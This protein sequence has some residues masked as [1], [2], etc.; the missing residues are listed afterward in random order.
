V[1]VD[2]HTPPPLRIVYFGTPAFAVPTLMAL[3][4]SRHK[5]VA[6]VSQ[7]DRPK[8]RGHRLAATPTKELAALCGVP[9][10]Q[11]T[12][13]REDT[14]L[15]TVAE[16][17]ADLGV[18]AAYGRILPDALLAIPRL[19]MINVHASLLPAWRGAAPV[20]RAVIA[21]DSVTGVT[22]MRVVQELDAG[23]MLARVTVPIGPDATSPEIETIL[24][25][26]G[27]AL[28]LDVVE[29]FAAGAVVETPQDHAQATFAPKILKTEGP[30]DWSLPAVRIH[31]L[32]RGLQPW[33]LASTTVD[34]ARFLIHRTAVATQANEAAPGTVVR[35]D[36][37]TLAVA[38]GAGVLEILQIQPEGRRPMTV[39]EFLSGHRVALNTRLPS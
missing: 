21:G 4:K 30:I 13:L 26:R 37:D 6:V 22:I 3:L 14:F 28:L 20:H 38:T 1:V 16:L 7:P 35:A 18:V 5:V 11:P 27:A 19:G 23:P 15:A 17:R 29:Q 39:R 34:G 10:L 33:P 31:N 25:D 8:G 36:G 2:V 24:A 12:K 9:V 32:V